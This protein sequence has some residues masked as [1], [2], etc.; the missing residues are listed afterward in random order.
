MKKIEEYLKVQGI[1]ND[2]IGVFLSLEASIKK[3]AK[4]VNFSD[5]G[6]VGTENVFGEQQVALDILSDK[7]LTDELAKNKNVGI[8][9]SEEKDG[10][11]TLSDGEYAVC[12]DPLDGSSLI[13]VN[14]A[15][16]TIVGIYKAKSFIGVKGDDQIG[17]MIA[18]YGPRT[19]ILLTVKSGVAEFRLNE[20]GD[21][22]LTRDNFNVKDGAMFSPGNLRACPY[23]EDYLRLVYQWVT[24]EYTL[25]YSGG[26]VP[27]INQI[28]LKGEGI[29]SY[30][31]YVEM[32]EGKLR[33]LFEC[34]P[35]ALLMEQVGGAASDGQMRILD[36]KVE[37]LNQR[38]PIY[39]GS[40]GEVERCED[41][42]G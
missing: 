11:K 27:D 9:A 13:D 40:K 24:E 4:A 34:A 36:K 35:I 39:V 22:V 17:A 16:G 28:I 19:T 37:D 8:V 5:T 31:A 23:R 20:N 1:D 7:I 30:P 12:F 41:Y 29:F 15:V 38:T 26:M 14:L 10:E 2:L 18:V 21:F 33:L 6:K 42:L 3:I 32:P 25:R